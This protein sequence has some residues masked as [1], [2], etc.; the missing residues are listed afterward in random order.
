VLKEKLLES[1]ESRRHHSSVATALN[2]PGQ[3]ER[4]GLLSVSTTDDELAEG[5]STAR[6]SRSVWFL[7]MCRGM[8][9]ARPIGD[10]L[11]QTGTVPATHLIWHGALQRALR[12][13]RAK[14]TLLTHLLGLLLH[15]FC[16]SCSLFP[17]P[18]PAGFRQPVNR[19]RRPTSKVAT[20]CSPRTTPILSTWPLARPRH[21][22]IH[23]KNGCTV[24]T[25]RAASSQNTHIYIQQLHTAQ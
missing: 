4:S 20:P 23:T 11:R 2:Y 9:G 6:S 12:G 25:S 17:T 19:R 18:G 10:G 14:T 22:N 15:F 3:V 7:A 13:C 8:A 5:T 21:E 16:P 24:I 1:K